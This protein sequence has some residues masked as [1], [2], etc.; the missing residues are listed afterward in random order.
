MAAQK[1]L[2]S[3]AWSELF[4][5]GVI[6]GASFLAIRVALDTIPVMTS[7]LHR[8]FWAMLV[9][10]VV[11]CVQRLAVPRSPRIW[12]A[13]LVMGLLNNAIPFSL[14]AWGQLYIETG[15]TSI[16]NAMTAIFG[17]IT[18]AL[19]FK[20]ERLTR[21][22]IIGVALGFLGVATAIGLQNFATFNLQSIAQLAI[23][24][25]TISYAMAG[26]WARA[27]L[28]DLPPVVAAA[29]MLTGSTV[30]ILPLTLMID[31]VPSLNLPLITWTAIGYYAVIA[32][33]GAYL[34]Y[35]RVLAMAGAGNL[36]LVT[37][38][39]PPVAIV[40]GAVL[41]DE[42]LPSQAYLGFAILALGLLILNR[43]GTRD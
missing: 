43:S 12:F 17:V 9:L 29:G 38:V 27:T 25:G 14:M 34:L 6:W 26:A 22:R 7:V 31:G 36:M 3:G 13:F 42:A 39:I 23:I 5:L 20:D 15:L 2:T 28:S 18:A 32:T 19:F 1:H 16:L 11:V 21:P 30:M 33:A 40:L 4:L 10:W 8:V 41:R 37:L 35:Y 24:A